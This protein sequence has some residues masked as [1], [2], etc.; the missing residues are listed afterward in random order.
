MRWNRETSGDWQFND[1]IYT[2]LGYE[3]IGDTAVLPRRRT[4]LNRAGRRG[5][6]RLAA[7]RHR[8][9]ELRM[10]DGLANARPSNEKPFGAASDA[11]HDAFIWYRRRAAVLRDLASASAA[12]VS[13]AA[14]SQRLWVARSHPCR[15]AGRALE[16]TCAR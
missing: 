10:T 12:R 1:H 9:V 8:V 13:R 7:V 11:H 4:R 5:Q 14:A 2:E 15:L 16:T 6:N 3:L